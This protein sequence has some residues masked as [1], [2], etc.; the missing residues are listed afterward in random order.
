M[1]NVH[2]PRLIDTGSFSRISDQTSLFWKK[3]FPRSNL[4]KLPSI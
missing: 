1:R 3:L 4:A 2:I